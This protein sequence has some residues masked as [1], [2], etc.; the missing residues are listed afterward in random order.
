MLE[1]YTFSVS[2]TTIIITEC[3]QR[4]KT[5]RTS[6][7]TFSQ[8][9]FTFWSRLYTF[10][11]FILTID[12]WFDIIRRPVEKSI[13]YPLE[14]EINLKCATWKKWVAHDHLFL[15][16]LSLCKSMGRELI[17]NSISLSV[18]RS[19]SVIAC[20]TSQNLFITYTSQTHR[21]TLYLTHHAPSQSS[22]GVSGLDIDLSAKGVKY[23][24]V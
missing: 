21:R 17:T 5:R 9:S 15:T 14:L 16:H 13:N 7:C 8:T 24:F 4:R 6:L 22:R 12:K 1:S 2:Y 19:F 11:K 10:E 18:V 3:S 23:L 20:R